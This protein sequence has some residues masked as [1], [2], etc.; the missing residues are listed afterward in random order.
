MKGVVN[1]RYTIDGKHFDAAIDYGKVLHHY[2]GNVTKTLPVKL[3]CLDMPDWDIHMMFIPQ[4]KE[5]Y[6]VLEMDEIIKETK[7]WMGAILNN[8]NNNVEE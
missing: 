3:Y 7:E 8:D 2:P 5:D 6:A 4:K 1:L